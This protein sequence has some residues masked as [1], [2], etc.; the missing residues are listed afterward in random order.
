MASATIP[1]P[2]RSVPMN[3]WILNSRLDLLLIVGTPLV[4][5]LGISLAKLKWSGDEITTFALISAIGHHLP[6]MMRAYGDRSLFARFRVRFLVAPLFLIAVA[7][8][9]SIWELKGVVLVAAFWGWWHYLAQAYGFMRIYDG[10][11]GAL[12]PT[13][14]WLDKAM[15]VA[16][17]A[18]AVVLARN[19][20]PVFLDLYYKCGGPLVPADLVT[21]LRTV[22]LGMTGLVTLA[23]AAHLVWSYAHGQPPSPV[24]LLLMSSTFGFYWYSMAT[25]DNVLVAYALFELFHDVQY[26]TI[27]WA[28]NRNRTARDPSVGA[29]TKFLFRKRG[30]LVCVYVALVYAYGSLDYGARQIDSGLFKQALLGVFLASTLL[31]YYYDGFIWKLR[32]DATRQPLGLKEG[33][34]PQV[35]S[36]RQMPG[37]ESRPA[38]QSGTPPVGSVPVG[39]GWKHAAGWVAFVVPVLMLTAMQL[40]GTSPLPDRWQAIAAVVP[41]NAL[42]H[43]NLAT[44]LE[45]K[46]DMPGAAAEYRKALVIHPA[47]DKAHYNL[48]RILSRSGQTR[49]AI[50]HYT[51]AIRLRPHYASAHNNLGALHLQQGEFS[52]AITDFEQALAC[53]PGN[54]G[55]ALNLALAHYQLGRQ[56]EVARDIPE[57]ASQYREALALNPQDPGLK[58]E[59]LQ[60]QSRLSQAAFRAMGERPL[61]GIAP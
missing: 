35:P 51:A 33:A 12:S 42:V 57:A 54:R 11:V 28:F 49:E 16:W 48:A 27:V 53:E 41:D 1:V 38:G 10:K 46:P 36:G 17:F 22:V 21:N 59:I 8:A 37:Q 40:R 4:V 9:A 5:L 14:R 26:L 44:A 15:C 47:Y 50:D 31:H 20:L 2:S 19:A 32:E 24:K 18:A 60:A 52:D 6:G 43:F 13:T 39:V 34:P 29:F 25:V 7:S 30:W 55:F 23:F 45:A 56:R 58:R 61:T 3:P